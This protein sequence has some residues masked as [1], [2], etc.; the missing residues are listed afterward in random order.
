MA[1]NR[2]SGTIR[3]FY[4]RGFGFIVRPDG[5]D[6]WFHIADSP[7]IEDENKLVAGAPVTFDVVTGKR[8]PVAVCVEL[9][10]A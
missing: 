3:R 8:G 1:G 2:E 7:G 6:L 5:C 4:D 9:L 10:E